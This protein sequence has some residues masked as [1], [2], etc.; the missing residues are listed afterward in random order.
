MEVSSLPFLHPRNA[1]FQ[2]LAAALERTG[3]GLAIAT[4]IKRN[5]RSFP[6][7]LENSRKNDRHNMRQGVFGSLHAR[8]R[9]REVG[10]CCEVRARARLAVCPSN[11]VDDK[12]ILLA[13]GMADR[14]A[15]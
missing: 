2:N 7:A 14:R 12:F 15:A 13:R 4:A 1:G 9:A 8:A 11:N 10:S 3:Y 5:D 6:V